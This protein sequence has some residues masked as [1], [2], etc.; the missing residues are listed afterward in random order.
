[1]NKIYSILFFFVGLICQS[2][3]ITVTDNSHN[4]TDLVN[5]LLGN[6]CVEVSNISISSPQSVAY[7]NQNRSAFPI[8][9]GVILR[10]GIATHTQ[11]TYT[12]NNLSGIASG[13]GTDAF[14]QNLSNS[15]SG[16]TTPILDLAF[17]EFVF[18][19]VSCAFCFRFLF[20]SY[21]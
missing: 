5:L 2:Q 1:M 19:P 17:L 16:S 21:L 7:F 9:E 8:A 15:S 14:L 11:G 4:A 13:G 3:T 12:G 18:V 10:S 20:S 6:S